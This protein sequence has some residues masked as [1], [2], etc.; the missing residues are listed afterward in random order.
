MELR[1]SATRQPGY[2]SGETL[3]GDTF[4][5]V[6][7]PSLW[8]VISTWLDAES[9]QKWQMVPERRQ[10]DSKIE[11]LLVAPEEV[12]ILKIASR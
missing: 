4:R 9:W 1:I 6:D 2:I 7:D 5:T 10:I 3:R 12:T 8:L 11:A